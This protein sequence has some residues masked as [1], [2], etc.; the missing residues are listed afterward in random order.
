MSRS[1]VLC[2]NGKELGLVG[3]S[4]QKA[5]SVTCPV[6]SFRRVHCRPPWCTLIVSSNPKLHFKTN[7]SQFR[8]PLM[9]LQHFMSLTWPFFHDRHHQKW[10]EIWSA[11]LE[12]T[13]YEFSY[14]G[15]K[16]CCRITSFWNIP[17]FFGV[18]KSWGRD[19]HE[20]EHC[21]DDFRKREHFWAQNAQTG[22]LGSIICSI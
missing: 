14:Y 17:E 10:G 6:F 16:K 11:N 4:C 15:Y 18:L 8:Y 9:I 22:Y 20:N 7:Q 1:F 5:W 21:N 3:T 12:S 2:K 13:W 19:T